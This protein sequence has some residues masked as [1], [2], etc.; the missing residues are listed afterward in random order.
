MSYS[1]QQYAMQRIFS[2]GLLEIVLF[3]IDMLL[4]FFTLCIAVLISKQQPKMLKMPVFQTL[5]VLQAVMVFRCVIEVTVSS[6]T[7]THEPECRVIVFLS[8]SLGLLPAYLCN[9]CLVYI[10]MTLIYKVAA[11]RRWPVAVLAMVCVLPAVVP[12]GFVLFLSPSTAGVRSFCEYGDVPNYRLFVFKWLVVNI[13]ILLAGIIGIVSI[14]MTILHIYRTSAL[15]REFKVER[16]DLTMPTDVV[17]RV[18]LVNRTLISV[19][20]FPV[21]PILA[22]YFTVLNSTIRYTGQRNYRSLDVID[23]VLQ[24]LQAWGI[25]LA[26]F[27]N[28]P[29]RRYIEE[30]LSRHHKHSP[31]V[32][33]PTYMRIFASGIP[34]PVQQNQV[35]R[36][37]PQASDSFV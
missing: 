10:Q 8:L 29:V 22:L 13:W 37:A 11:W 3:S 34:D 32:R 25:S 19:V 5:L 7:L 16:M 26:F 28:P 35:I 2:Q 23:T 17:Q 33:P 24:F 20:W 21:T 14:S 31:E 18:T 6:V 15:A 30:L 12:P 4:S 1:N 9:F 27:T 36:I